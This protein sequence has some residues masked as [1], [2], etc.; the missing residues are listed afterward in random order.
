MESSWLKRKIIRWMEDNR[1][2]ILTLV[3]LPLSFLFDQAMQV[4][5]ECPVQPDFL[6]YQDYILIVWRNNKL[7]V[8]FDCSV[9]KEDARKTKEALPTGHH[10]LNLTSV[11]RQFRNWWYRVFLA[12]PRNHSKRVAKIQAQASHYLPLWQCVFPHLSG[13]NKSLI[14][15]NSRLVA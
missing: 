8:T 13:F 6:Q 12:S 14:C 10:S 9:L 5:K 7:C 11:Y 1:G 15:S 4:P 3:G 2:L